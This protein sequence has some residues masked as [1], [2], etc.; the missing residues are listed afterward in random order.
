MALYYRIEFNKQ[1]KAEEL[2]I[3]LSKI[4]SFIGPIGINISDF[5]DENFETDKV[6]KKEGYSDEMLWINEGD[7]FNYLE[8]Y[9][10]IFFKEKIGAK[11]TLI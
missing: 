3:I 2:G 7:F 9:L 10:K 11:K 1:I 4:N 8:G 5:N 6:L